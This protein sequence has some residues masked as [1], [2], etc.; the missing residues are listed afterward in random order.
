MVYARDVDRRV[1]DVKVIWEVEWTSI[2][3]RLVDNDDRNGVDG[4]QQ[5]C[6]PNL[7]SMRT[8]EV[9]LA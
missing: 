1:T 4:F 2:G 8:S 5:R 6:T 7:Q 3:P 9:D